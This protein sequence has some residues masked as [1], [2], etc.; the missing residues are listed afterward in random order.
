MWSLSHRPSN[1]CSLSH[2]FTG[3]LAIR[4]VEI[5][6]LR[7]EYTLTVGGGQINLVAIKGESGIHVFKRSLGKYGALPED[8]YKEF[9]FLV[10][11]PPCPHLLQPTAAVVDESGFRGFLLP[12]QPAGSLNIVFS[13][14]VGVVLDGAESH[15]M[16]SME[17]RAGKL[18][19]LFKVNLAW[20]IVQGLS[21]LHAQA[22]F[23]GDLTLI[24]IVLCHDGYCRFIDYYPSRCC[25]TS[26]PPEFSTGPFTGPQDI[27]SLGLVLWCVAHEV[28]SFT[29]M[30]YETPVLHWAQSIP[31]W[32]KEIVLK[33]VQYQPEGR[34]TAME[35]YD[36]FT[37]KLA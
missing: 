15:T 7:C 11:L 18:S 2:P 24:N 28:G 1:L 22:I 36:I 5:G 35:V 6:S 14:N 27:F 37:A 13:D 9:L 31:L 29:R 17:I 12:H 3:P 20:D 21:A 33:C 30:Q 26:A 23:W 19:W 4:S 32:Y 8:I 10:N 16:D 25:I 34:P